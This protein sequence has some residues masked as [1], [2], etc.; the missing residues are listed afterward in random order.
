MHPV[1]PPWFQFLQTKVGP[2]TDVF[3]AFLTAVTLLGW[4]QVG[5][6]MFPRWMG[7]GPKAIRVLGVLALVC[8]VVLTE[9][10]FYLVF[11][12]SN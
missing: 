1:L 12:N 11:L 5:V 3:G 7:V 10:L 4:P 9:K 8:G 6:R 2:W